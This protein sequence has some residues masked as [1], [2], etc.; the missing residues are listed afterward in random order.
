MPRSTAIGPYSS[1]ILKDSKVEG[2][3]VILTFDHSGAGLRTVDVDEARGFAIC[4]EDR[5]WVWASA[6][7]LPDTGVSP[8][9]PRGNQIVVS[10]PVVA[11]PVAVRY[12]WADN[13]VG[14]VF[15]AEGLPLTPFR[16]DSFPMITDPKNPNG[17]VATAAK[18]QEELRQIQLKRAEA[19]K[20]RQQKGAKRQATAQ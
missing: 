5:K 1:P 14:N 7:I 8:R 11:T 6:T 15:S 4:G 18:R 20:K 13:P 17:L 19:L 3:K 2:N 16:T 10:S 12:N 9:T